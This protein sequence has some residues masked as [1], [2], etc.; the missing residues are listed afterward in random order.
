MNG[1]FDYDKKLA[2]HDA[3]SVAKNVQSQALLPQQGRGSDAIE[4]PEMEL[5]C[6]VWY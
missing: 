1:I 4:K 6:S 2:P 5:G 3:P